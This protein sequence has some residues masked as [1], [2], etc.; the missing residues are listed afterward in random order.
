MSPDAN[1]QQQQSKQKEF[2]QLLPLIVEVAGLPKSEP[3]RYLT[4]EQMEIRANTLK[5]A[6]K[7]ARQLVVDVSK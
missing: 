5:H 7:I 2:M 6:Y 1:L 4:P 3:G